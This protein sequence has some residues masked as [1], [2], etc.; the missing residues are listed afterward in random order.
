M[1]PDTLFLGITWYVVFLLSTTCHEASHAFAAKLGG[2]LTAFHGGQV[3]LDPL[4]HI[5]REPFGMVL[6]PILSFVTGGWMMGWASAPY[7]PRWAMI[8]PRR[9]AWM[10][11]A[12][13]AANLTLAVLAAIGIRIGMMMGVFQ[14]PRGL[15]FAHIVSSANPG[16]GDGA[17]T[18]LSILFSLNLLLCVFNLLP[19]PPLDGFEAIGVFLPERIARK[20]VEFGMQLRGWSI[21]GLLIAWQVF[22]QVFYPVFT[23]ALSTLLRR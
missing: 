9:A 18:L 4:P 14:V 1:T 15:S 19:L 2:D 16:A 20:L 6:F 11:L 10:S 22:D 13:P 12:G 7:D 21:F 3:S 5:R 23:F 8:Y 17:A